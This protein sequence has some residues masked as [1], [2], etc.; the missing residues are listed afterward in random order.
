MPGE[1]ESRLLNG[2]GYKWFL[3][4]VLSPIE[5]LSFAVKYRTEYFPDREM[6]GSGNDLVT[7]N[8][9]RDLRIYM[10]IEI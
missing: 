4:M 6:L 10:R 8:A 7:G 9:R 2:R 3:L 5:L 1:L